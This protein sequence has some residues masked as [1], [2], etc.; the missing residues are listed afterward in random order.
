MSIIPFPSVRKYD[1]TAPN[2]ASAPRDPRDIGTYYRGRGPG[3]V[4][5]ADGR[6]RDSQNK[7]AHFLGLFAD[8]V[9][10]MCGRVR[11]IFARVSGAGFD[12]IG[13]VSPA[14]P[15]PAV[16]GAATPTSAGTKPAQRRDDLQVLFFLPISILHQLQRGAPLAS[17]WQLN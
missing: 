3:R 12:L 10:R 14:P 4:G 13:I 2:L 8:V 9:D 15:D 6:R 1:F 11:L 7:I 16:D 5:L 17:K